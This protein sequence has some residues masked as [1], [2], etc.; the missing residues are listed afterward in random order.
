VEKRYNEN[1]VNTKTKTGRMGRPRSFD[2]EAALDNAM[3]VFREKGYEGASLSDLTRAMGIN[4]PSMYA[5]FGDKESL[6]RRVL[7]RYSCNMNAVFQQALQAATAR[8]VAE[9][10]LRTAVEMQT[11]NGNPRGCLIT[12]GALVCGTEGEPIRHELSIRRH[13]QEATIRERL[14]RARKEGDLPPGTNPAD[15]A[16]Y[17]TT[18][19]QGISVLATGGATR[20]QLRKVADTALRAWPK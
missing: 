1:V 8:E 9:R 6:F 11:R 20:A 10:L 7:D 17:L 19:M 18:V 14:V 13:Q 5:A 16:R 12:Q 15:L 3:R 2:T 4:R